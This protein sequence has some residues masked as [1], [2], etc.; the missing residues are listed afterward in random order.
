MQR[1]SN[2]LKT[3][4]WYLDR[5]AAAFLAIS[6]VY[7]G[8]GQLIFWPLGGTLSYWW[9]ALHAPP[10]IYLILSLA[11]RSPLTALK[12][13]VAMPICFVSSIFGLFAWG[14]YNGP[15]DWALAATGLIFLLISVGAG[16]VIWIN[17][18]NIE[19]SRR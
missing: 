19:A 8:I 3:M 13:G 16:F 4:F 9:P 10:V 2:M 5:A 14:S 18:T 17:T 11:V 12:V 15:D 1:L 6:F 7:F